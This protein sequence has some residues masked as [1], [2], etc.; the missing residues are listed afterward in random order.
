M[1][2]LVEL[3]LPKTL[4]LLTISVYVFGL[5]SLQFP[6]LLVPSSSPR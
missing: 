5:I 1:S 3:G 4:P 6:L 2:T